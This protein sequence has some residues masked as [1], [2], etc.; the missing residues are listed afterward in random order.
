MTAGPGGRRQPSPRGLDAVECTQ[1]DTPDRRI[2]T[3]ALASGLLTTAIGFVGI[4]RPSLW[5]DEAASSSAAA[6]PLDTIPA[7]LRDVDV[8]HGLYYVLLHGWCHVFGTSAVALRSPSAIALGVACAGCVVLAHH[9]GGRTVALVAGGTFALLPGLAWSA[10]EAREWSSATAVVTWAT[11]ALVYA[12][13][14]DRRRW[15]VGYAALMVV[16]ITL[17]VMT[18]LMAGPHLWLARRTGRLRQAVLAVASAVVVTLPLLHEAFTQRGQVAWIQL[19]PVQVAVRVVTTQLFA[20]DQN[21]GYPHELLVGTVLAGVSV[22]AGLAGLA[23][24]RPGAG[25]GAVWFTVPTVLLAVPVVLGVQLYQDR[26]LTFAAPGAVLLVAEGVVALHHRTTGRAGL[27]TLAACGVLLAI[28]AAVTALAAQRDPSAKAGDDYRT[29]AAAAR[30]ADQ[31]FYERADAR[32]IRLAY[33]DDLV[34]VQDVLLTGDPAATGTLWGTERAGD[35]VRPEGV[36]V[37]YVFTVEPRGSRARLV[38]FLRDDGCSLED[39]HVAARWTALRWS[40][41]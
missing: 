20:A 14:A 41:P 3:I 9:L 25:L 32:G 19:S 12:V 33:P 38:P 15:W 8:V 29:L 35:P 7:L 31:V 17:S 39:R 2:R 27:R 28:V 18:V 26:Y 34:G 13:G 10:T 22:V 4:G 6:R 16:A 37:T 23:A 24:R 30:G 40:C 5:Y 1:P 11:V 21:H 36:V